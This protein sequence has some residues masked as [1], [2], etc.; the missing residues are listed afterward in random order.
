MRPLFVLRWAARDLR[1]RWTQVV[2]IALIIAIGTGVYSA[3]G[4]GATWA[5]ESYDASFGL[6]HM[7]DLRVKAA[8]GAGA[9]TGEMLAVLDTLPD[10]GIVATAEERL[11]VPTQVDAST[12]DQ[13]ILVPGRIVGM[14]LSG[15]GPHVNDVYVAGGDGRDLTAADDGR[16]VALLESNFADHYGL[17]P[18]GAVRVAGDRPVD[19]VG[20]A[21]APEYFFVMTEEGGFFAEA[22]FAA[23]FTSLTTAQDL[24]GRPGQ[25]NDLVLTLAPGVDQDEAAAALRDAFAASGTGLGVTVMKTSD[26]DAYQVLY[27]DIEGDQKLWS[28]LAGLILAGAAFGAFNL[29]SRMVEA[30][31]REIGI[32]MALGW[33]RWRLAVRPLLA[34]VQ[35][36]FLGAVFGVGV[37]LLVMAALRPVYRSV[38]PLPVWRMDFQPDVFARAALLGFVLPLLAT[39]WPVWRAVRVMPVDAISTAHR[40]S[41]G[42]LAPLLRRLPW[43]VSAFRRMP[44]GNVLRT[45]RRTVLTALGIGAAITTL[46][47]IFGMLDS[48]EATMDRNERELLGTHPDRLVVALDGLVAEDGPEVGAVR[49]AAS[50]GGVAPVL[51]SGAVLVAPGGTGTEDDIDVLLEAIDLDGDLWTPTAEEGSLPAGREGIVL[52]RSAAED[53]DVGPGDSV[54]LEHLARQG[55][56][57]ALVRSPIEVAAVHPSPFRF[58][59]YVDRSQLAAF[60]VPGIVNS[61]YVVPAPGYGVED[62]ERELFGLPGVASVQPVATSTRIVQDS[63]EEFTAIYRVLQVFILFLALLIAYNATSINADER[64]RERATLFAFGLPMRRVMGLE[65]VEGVLVGLLG[66]L[67]GMGLGVVIV[68]LLITST[69][70]TTMPEMGLDVV[71]SWG[72]VLGAMVLGVLAVAIAPLLTLRR[73][74]RM[75]IPGTLRVVE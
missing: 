5:R 68:R 58:S 7:Y 24:A 10:P 40:T 36:A 14:D 21:A 4:S 41:R 31:R 11:V 73:L 38:L 50:V 16:P 56:G 3:L 15:G 9:P 71:V 61:L 51:R 49:G 45:P 42:G 70:R 20:I 23:L 63:M 65:V 43:P 48:F 53:L 6:L 19:T 62:V 47:A 59:A 39:A 32:G 1:R 2:V 72:T 75:D 22:N 54:T 46:V 29:A 27:D 8:E 74:R 60:G 26:E 44:L 12:G 13:T 17:R 67:V 57:F 25:V 64:A 35:I 55:D 30:Q 37:G 69:M 33:S 34:G 18:G 28:I 52:A 66:T